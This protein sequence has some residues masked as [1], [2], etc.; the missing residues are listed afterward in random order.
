ME[1][2]KTMG[3]QEYVSITA[4]I[5]TAHNKSFLGV[6]V[7]WIDAKTLERKKASI[8]CRRFKGRHTYDA[9]ATEL[10]DIFSQ[11]GLTH[12]KVTACVADNGSNF[13]KAFREY[14]PQVD[15][16]VEDDDANHEDGDV[17]FTDVHSVLN[18]DDE[19]AQHGLCVLPP[20]YRCAAH[21]LNLIANNEV[22]A[23]LASNP[24]SRSVYR[25]A[26]AKCSSMWTKASR[27][28]LASE[29]L[30]EAGSKKLIVPTA[31]RWNSYFN[32]YARIAEMPLTVINNI[33][34]KL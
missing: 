14:Q 15:S 8:A 2:K 12:D 25:S 9:I 18:E 3:A 33:C 34:T 29:Y 7:H 22:D 27:S 16:E 26:T 21:T 6:T 31:T 13:V 4:D 24:E 28:S 32:A 20:H 17:T 1:L 10:E 30:E 19:D 11:C 23:W 5:W